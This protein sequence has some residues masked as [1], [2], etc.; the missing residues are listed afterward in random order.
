MNTSGLYE[1]AMFATPAGAPPIV[2]AKGL[3]IQALVFQSALL[4]Q[5]GKGGKETG[6]E[7]VDI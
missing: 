4:V 6:K 5:D 2:L 7:Q 3:G 1:Q